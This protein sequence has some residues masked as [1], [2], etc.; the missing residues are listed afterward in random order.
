MKTT[1]KETVYPTGKQGIKGKSK[2][3]RTPLRSI[4]LSKGIWIAVILA[5]FALPVVVT[6]NSTLFLLTNIFIWSVFAMSYNLLLGF[7][8][9]I[10]FGHVMFF[11]IGAY[12]MALTAKFV[13][14]GEFGFLLALILTVGICFILSFLVGLLSLR[15]K[16][17]FYALITLAV[18]TIF[19]IIAEQWRS[20]TMGNDGFNFTVMLSKDLFGFINLLDRMHIYYIALLFLISM[21]LVLK[22]FIDSPVGRTLQAI[23]DNEGRAASLGYAVLNYKLLSNILAGVVAGLAGM[24][25]AISIR[26]VSPDSVLGVE[27]TIDVLLM[28]MIGG[29][30]TLLGP[31]VGATVVEVSSH[32]LMTLSH[33]HPIFERWVILFGIVFI[34]I[35]LFFPAGIVGTIKQKIRGKN[36][37]GASL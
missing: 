11:G 3:D 26:F 12:S 19:V 2:I 8:G 5:L 34:L 16:D 35:V 6:Q 30:G 15:L 22:R 24:V 7:T 1:A 29:V 10:S 36:K 33:I 27:N 28:T 9:I 23:R 13:P 14:Q 25:Y 31:V 4:K 17:T 20:M 18:A 37:E 32:Y 21:Y